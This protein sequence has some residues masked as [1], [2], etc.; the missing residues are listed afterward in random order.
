MIPSPKKLKGHADYSMEKNLN[1][2]DFLKVELPDKN[3]EMF[4]GHPLS[5]D[6]LFSLFAWNELCNFSKVKRSV[7]DSITKCIWTDTAQ[8]SVVFIQEKLKNCRKSQDAAHTE[9]E[10]TIFITSPQGKIIGGTIGEIRS[11]SNFGNWC[12]IDSVAINSD[13]RKRQLGR[14]LFKNI[15]AYA[16]KKNCRFQQLWTYEWQ[17]RGFYEK[18]GFDVVATY[19]RSEHQWNQEG[20]YL[21]KYLEV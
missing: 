19:P 5:A 17:A 18:M 11:F 20:Y 8:K 15:D 12:Y 6:S 4:I 1:K 9:N 3:Y 10:Y 21:R 13:Y 7:V 16:R 14:E 2:D